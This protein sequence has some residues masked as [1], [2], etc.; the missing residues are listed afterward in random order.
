MWH[1]P[2]KR[3]GLLNTLPQKNWT[4]S[5]NYYLWLTGTAVLF[6]S[7]PVTCLLVIA[8]FAFSWCLTVIFEN[9]VFHRGSLFKVGSP[10]KM[11]V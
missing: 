3:I 8:K 11:L 1:L 4:S 6:R 2:R 10:Q 7:D 5:G 9:L